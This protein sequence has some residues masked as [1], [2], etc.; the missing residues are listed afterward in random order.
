MLSGCALSGLSPFAYPRPWDYTRKKP[1]DSSLVGSYHLLKL[2]NSPDGVDPKGTFKIVLR[3]DKTAELENI[4]QLDGFGE[5]KLCDFSGS[6]QWEVLDLGQ[7]DLRLSVLHLKE[8]RQSYKCP[9]SFNI[10]FM[11]LGKSAPHRLYLVFGDPDSDIGMEFKR[12]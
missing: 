9:P 6:G 4:P 11:L 8:T 5:H 1:T 7:G 3:A 12:D 2:S 10:D